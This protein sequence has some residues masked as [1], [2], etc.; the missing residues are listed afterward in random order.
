MYL[1]SI[2]L[3]SYG[4]VSAKVSKSTQLR[5]IMI[6]L[7]VKEYAKQE[8]ISETAVRKR[9]LSGLCLSTQLNDL[10]YIA[11]EDNQPS[12]IKDLRNKI[13]LLNAKINTLKSESKAVNRQNDYVDKLESRVDYL[14]SKIDDL[15]TKL[16]ESTI[17]KESLYEKVLNTL[18]IENKPS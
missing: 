14:E 4:I 9:V 2:Y 5:I 15:M 8:A 10:T 13:R 11:I 17:K 1:F 12:I 6:L 16:E 3:S 18:V 7:T